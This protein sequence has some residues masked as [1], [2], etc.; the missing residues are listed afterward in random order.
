MSVDYVHVCVL[1]GLRHPHEFVNLVVASSDAVGVDCV[2]NVCD[3]LLGWRCLAVLLLTLR[4]VL[5][6][7]SRCI[8][9]VVHLSIR[10]IELHFL[11]AH[12][13]EWLQVCVARCGRVG[14]IS[15]SHGV[16]GLLRRHR[17][18]LAPEKAAGVGDR[19]VGILVALLGVVQAVIQACLL[20][21]QSC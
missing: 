12:H 15:S 21:V 1:V 16:V 9:L 7:T 17:L 10:L 13:S 5:A 4:L 6:R 19:L 3:V 11:G 8:C 20:I 18:G 14:R 2:E